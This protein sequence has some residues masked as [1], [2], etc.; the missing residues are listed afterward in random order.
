MSYCM[1]STDRGD[2]L[3]T[4]KNH[5]LCLQYNFSMKCYHIHTASY[6]DLSLAT[7][8]MNSWRT[9]LVLLYAVYQQVTKILSKPLCRQKNKRLSLQKL[10]SLVLKFLLVEWLAVYTPS[11]YVY[12]VVELTFIFHYEWN[13]WLLVVL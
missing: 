1:Y 7:K 3:V 11:L 5:S 13:A 10:K 2:K 8:F 9:V 12:C 4:T 6:S